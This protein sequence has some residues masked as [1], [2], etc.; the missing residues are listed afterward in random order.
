M[1]HPRLL[2]VGLMLVTAAA[3]PADPA[4]RAPKV[5]RELLE[6]R[7]EAARSVFKQT[8]ARLKTGEPR[9][10]E[11]CGWSERWLNAELALAEKPAD[12]AKALREHV[13]RTQ[14]VERAAVAFAKAGQWRQSD[15]D[16]ATY[17]RLEAEIRLIKEGGDDK[18][19]AQGK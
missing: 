10:S 13:D 16:A 15:A 8:L 12:R 2:S 6:K 7:A 19:P 4:P 1:L 5:P 9:P 18:N 3:S 17:F 11:L 14:E